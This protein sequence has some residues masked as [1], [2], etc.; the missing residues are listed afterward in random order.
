M[1]NRG[2][3]TPL[4]DAE[5]YAFYQHMM[6]ADQLDF[7]SP[8]RI[9]RSQIQI[10][11]Q[12]LHHPLIRTYLQDALRNLARSKGFSNFAV[13]D[14]QA[15]HMQ[16]TILDFAREQ[17]TKFDSCPICL[18]FFT[19]DSAPYLTTSD[20]TTRFAY[21]VW[22]R[23]LDLT[24][25]Q[26][27]IAIGSP[28]LTFHQEWDSMVV[29]TVIPAEATSLPTP[30]LPRCQRQ[31]WDQGCFE[32]VAGSTARTKI[33]HTLQ[34]AI[35]DLQKDMS[36]R[37][38]YEGVESTTAAKFTAMPLREFPTR[39]RPEDER[40]ISARAAETRTTSTPM[41]KALPSS[42]G[43]DTVE[44][45]TDLIAWYIGGLEHKLSCQ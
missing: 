19:G 34:E 35:D 8:H 29:P 38:S 25:D 39:M 40:R 21:G 14:K 45:E 5:Y 30:T 2:L 17:T 32:G 9:T 10:M 37:G 22:A 6:K 26:L 4:G 18:T 13:S 11:T 20:Y 7:P 28:A 41:K 36:S 33:I 27:A 16:K 44:T 1:R 43:A 31:R 3:L 23:L 15:V 12:V 24:R 42:T